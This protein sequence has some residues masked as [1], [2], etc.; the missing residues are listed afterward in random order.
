MVLMHSRQHSDYVP[1]DFPCSHPYM[2]ARTHTGRRHSHTVFLLCIQTD[3]IDWSCG[4]NSLRQIYGKTL[5]NYSSQADTVI[6]HSLPGGRLVRPNEPPSA[7]RCILTGDVSWCMIRNLLL[8]HAVLQSY[9][10]LC[11]IYLWT[12][13]TYSIEMNK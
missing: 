5:T 13:T 11:C 10:A 3:S 1:F 8:V 4:G 12:I 7:L 2:R 6:H 9:V